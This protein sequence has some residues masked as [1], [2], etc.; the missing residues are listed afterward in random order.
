MRE[1]VPTMRRKFKLAALLIM[2]AALLSGCVD[3]SAMFDESM[4]DPDATPEP[5]VG[6]LTA[7]VFTDLEPVYKWYNEVSIGDMLT[8][9]TEKYGEPVVAETTDGANY[10]WTDENGHGFA[11]VFFENGRLR[12]KVLVYEDV[13]QLKD[14]SAATGLNNV[15]T[16]TQDYDFDMVC[17]ILGGKP[18]EIAAIA[19]DSTV[20]PEVKRLF[21]WLDTKGNCV[22]VLFSAKEE[23]EQVNYNFVDEAAE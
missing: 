11:A 3:Y 13:R 17:S 9:L 5:T 23:L 20:N 12:A 16:L 8:D 7:P 18:L 21:T 1:D 2:V 22:Q 6:P 19:Q 10:T 15:T 14:I 4:I